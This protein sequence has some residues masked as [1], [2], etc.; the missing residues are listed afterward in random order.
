MTPGAAGA[1]ADPLSTRRILMV[2]TPAGGVVHME[3]K[4]VAAFRAAGATSCARATTVS[5]LG[6]HEGLAFRVLCRHA[7]LR[8]AGERRLYLDEPAWEALRSARRRLAV[9][10]MGFVLLMTIVA[11]AWA[12]RR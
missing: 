4:I 12:L 3:K 7:V 2:A 5:A 1:V 6:I 9:T 8:E 11:F 10:I